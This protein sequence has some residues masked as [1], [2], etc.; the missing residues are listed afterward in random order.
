MEI[1]VIINMQLLSELE[2]EWIED[3]DKRIESELL[4]IHCQEALRYCAMNNICGKK[5][6]DMNYY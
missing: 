4:N 6:T 2:I 3:R 1:F 5:G